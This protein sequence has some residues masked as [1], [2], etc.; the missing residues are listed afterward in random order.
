MRLALDVKQYPNPYKT[1]QNPCLQIP[2]HHA[3][4]ILQNISNL[5]NSVKMVNFQEEMVDPRCKL[6]S[7]LIPEST[8]SGPEALEV[9]AGK[10]FNCS[11]CHK[12]LSSRQNL[13]EHENI[14]TGRRPYSCRVPGCDASFRQGSQL[15]LHRK[16][17]QKNE[18]QILASRERINWLVLPP[19]TLVKVASTIPN[20][21]TM[22][23][24]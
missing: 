1:I 13:R 2:S 23:R 21:F 14:H 7:G 24:C 22:I 11:F 12:S 17:H 4:L 10:S 3:K 9:R 8:L 18:A 5:M 20:V 16:C 6:P 15:S 19:I